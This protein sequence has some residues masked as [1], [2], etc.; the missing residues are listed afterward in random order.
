LPVRGLAAL[1]S[2][3]L[4][5]TGTPAQTESSTQAPGAATPPN[6]AE[7]DYE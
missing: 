1:A 7:G 4:G 3:L 6:P 2:R 5:D